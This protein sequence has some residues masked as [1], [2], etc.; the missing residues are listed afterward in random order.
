MLAAAASELLSDA[1]GNE[2]LK[3]QVIDEVV[4]LM[5]R[6]A[7]ISKDNRLISRE[8]EGNVQELMADTG[9][10]KLTSKRV[11]SI[12]AFLEQLVN[13]FQLNETRIR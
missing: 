2:S 11:E 9:Q 5:E 12:T 8:V 13:Q 1:A 6:I 7:E 4:R 10:V 3:M